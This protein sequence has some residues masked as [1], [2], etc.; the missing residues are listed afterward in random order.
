MTTLRLNSRHATWMVLVAFSGAIAAY[1][2]PNAVAEDAIEM[3]A[4]AIIIGV[5]AVAT[6]GLTQHRR[7]WRWIVR[8]TRCSSPATPSTRSSSG[9]WGTTRIRASPTSPTS[10]GTR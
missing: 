3:L 1:F 4:V 6:G 7:A 8:A 2:L 5:A 9:S 10:P